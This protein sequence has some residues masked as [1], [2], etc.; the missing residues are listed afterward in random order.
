MEQ[1]SRYFKRVGHVEIDFG[2]GKPVAYYGLDFKFRVNRVM[3]ERPKTIVE[4]G[5]LGL[6]DVNVQ[7][8]TTFCNESMALRGGEG[9]KPKRIVIYAGYDDNG[10]GESEVPIVSADIIYAYPTPYPDN[11]VQI[12]ALTGYRY[13]RRH[14]DF[15]INDKNA[16]FLDLVKK[17]EAVLKIKADLSKCPDSIQKKVIGVCQC[18]KDTYSIIGMLNTKGGVYS[19]FND[20]MDAET[21]I[22]ELSLCIVERKPKEPGP[23]DMTISTETGM[24]GIPHIENHCTLSVDTFLNPHLRIN[25]YVKI[26][27]VVV[28][29]LNAGTYRIIEL[30]HRGQFRGRDW[31]THIKAIDHNM[32]K[33]GF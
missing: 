19:Y 28:P 11:W 14:S 6:N 30:E 8:I 29:S 20:S 21:G 2:D 5:I 12:R 32:L 10:K 1:N 25:S 15:A 9:K 7:R 18:T 27:S 23:I 16:T 4:C 26:D 3:D 17:A 31:Y 24:I 33:R 22:N 13:K